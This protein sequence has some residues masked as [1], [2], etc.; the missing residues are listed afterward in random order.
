MD[1]KSIE[2]M[3]S[4]RAQQTQASKQKQFDKVFQRALLYLERS[5]QEEFRKAETLMNAS[6]TFIDAIT[7]QRKDIRPYLALAY[8]FAIL[9]DFETAEEYAYA[10][11][12]WEPDNVELTT[13]VDEMLAF[14]KELRARAAQRAPSG[15]GLDLQVPERAPQAESAPE[16]VDYPAL[17]AKLETFI[18]D[19]LRDLFSNPVNSEPTVDA[20]KYKAH[21][22]SL[23]RLK[24]V[25]AYMEQQIAIVEKGGLNTSGLR[26]KISPFKVLKERYEQAIQSSKMLM[27]INDTIELWS[28]KTN[29]QVEVV[30]QRLTMSALTYG[31]VDV[32][33]MMDGCDLIADKLDHLCESENIDIQLVEGSY[34]KLIQLVESL[35]DMVDDSA[36]VQENQNKL[37]DILS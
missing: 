30:N 1:F 4:Q 33:R 35:N 27:E 34:E 23:K 17:Y 29:K 10:A 24:Q 15:P 9:E 36:V 6:D 5:H 25:I 28:F 11:V 3:S 2:N 21:M 12:Q 18:L 7:I 13:F 37:A 22:Q 19:K 26:D 32:N 31:R 8:I 20:K 14:K 16:Q